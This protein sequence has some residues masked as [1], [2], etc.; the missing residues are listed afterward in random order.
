MA[1]LDSIES[2][3]D[4]KKLS[5]GEL[6]ALAAEIRERIVETVGRNGGHLSS[7]LGAVELTLA[8]HRVFDSPRDAIVWDVGHQSYAHKLVTGR[9]DRF[10]SIRKSGG[11][12]G[13]PK[14]SESPHDIFDTGHASTSISAALGLLE[15]RRLAGQGGVAVAVIGDGALTGGMAY[16]A[17]S[18]AGQ[19]GLPLIVV[20]NDNKMSISPNVGALSSYLSRLSATVRY[21]GIRSRIDRAVKGIPFAG[22]L[23]YSRMVRAKRAVKALFFKEN[24]FSD[25]GFE[26]AGPIDG[27]NIPAMIQV[28]REARVLGKPVVVHLVT[29]KGKG[30][31]LA[32]EDPSRYHGVAPNRGVG[33]SAPRPAASFT[34]AFS[35]AIAD[36]GRSDGRIV[37]VTAAMR[38]GVG[39]D[40]FA[41]AC[42]GR[43]HDVGIAEEH[44][45]TFAAGLAAAGAKPVVAVYS[46]FVQRAVDQ[47]FHDVA[48]PGLPVVIA[49]DR[50]G[51]V[52]EDGETHQGL[53]D[54]AIFRSFPNLSILAPASAVELGLM[55]E[56]ALSSGQP[57]IIRYPKAI[58]PFEAPAYA[59]PIAPGRGV[60]LRRSGAD[61][62]LVALGSLA[63][64]AARAADALCAEAGQS[65]SRPAMS[66]RSRGGADVYSPRFVAPFDE[67]AFLEVA[68]PY[69]RVIALEE[70][71]ER[72]GFGERLVSLITARLPGVAA[73]SAGFPSLPFAQASRSELLSR[74]GLDV[75]GIAA[76]AR[77]AE[78]SEA[79]DRIFLFRSREAGA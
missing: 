36:R 10:D 11:L 48:L 20:L 7:N 69:K 23:L 72:G 13:F 71:V 41:A 70:G 24:F 46:T 37:A 74:A 68:A 45:V 32:E 65:S 52:G 53:Y 26:Y 28:L 19:L 55:L 43:F 76:R 61:T 22:G 54:I 42:P 30:Y 56:W 57:A 25:L 35:R 31:D 58:C 60:F 39:L 2:P 33:G 18:H 64:P 50:A 38:T 63:D 75:E 21:Q 6:K 3:Q 40:A 77:A 17:L 79:S 62:L 47:V 1:L 51:A 14:R 49:L 16:E 29:R 8:I 66:P 4:L 12:S 34:E 27:H 59:E 44:A 78:A 5:L 73:F 15:G 67:E 9:R